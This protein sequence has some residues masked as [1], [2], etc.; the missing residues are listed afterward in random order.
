MTH[1]S[2][3]RVDMHDTT[4]DWADSGTTE[5]DKAKFIAGDEFLAALSFF[6]LRF[7]IQYFLSEFNLND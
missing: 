7:W 5:Y 4:T 3:T 6:P 1:L 2:K